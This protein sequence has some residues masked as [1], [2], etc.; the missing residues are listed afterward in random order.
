MSKVR[1]TKSSVSKEAPISSEYL[2]ELVKTDEAIQLYNLKNDLIKY[3]LEKLQIKSSK[4]KFLVQATNVGSGS[5]IDI[6]ILIA[7]SFGAVWD[8][9]RDGY[10]NL[11][12]DNSESDRVDNLLISVYWIFVD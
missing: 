3:I 11:Q 9:E 6:P 10:I 5:P 1:V 7:S 4:Y 8:G 2:E 12:V